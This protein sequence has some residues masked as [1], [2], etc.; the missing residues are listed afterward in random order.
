METWRLFFRKIYK[1]YNEE[2]YEY[3]QGLKVPLNQKTSKP[4]LY[5][6]KVGVKAV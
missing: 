2:V 1:P 3:R 5:F 4:I 6:N